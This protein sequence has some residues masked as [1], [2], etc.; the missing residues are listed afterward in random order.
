MNSGIATKERLSESQKSARNA[1][2]DLVV[3]LAAAGSGKTRV[4]IET[5]LKHVL[6]GRIPMQRMA[7]VTFTKKAADE[8]KTRDMA[9][10]QARS[11]FHLPCCQLWEG[12]PPCSCGISEK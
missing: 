3:V 11:A 10:E 4:L 6:Q 1:E 8:M 7:A 12:T 2:S 9:R 5:F